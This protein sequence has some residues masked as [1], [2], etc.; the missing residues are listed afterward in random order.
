MTASLTPSLRLEAPAACK[1]R[2]GSGERDEGNAGS[3]AEGNQR[4]GVVQADRTV[5]GGVDEVVERVDARECAPG[6]VERA[7]GVEDA[8]EERQRCDNDA[9]DEGVLVERLRPDAG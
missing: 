2:R 7:G 5:P 9:G 4:R 6:F 1:E 3:P 8:A